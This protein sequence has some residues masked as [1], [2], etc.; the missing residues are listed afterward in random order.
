VYSAYLWDLHW[1][2]LRKVAREDNIP[3]VELGWARRE[4]IMK[5]SPW[6]GNSRP[7]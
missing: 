4:G 7:R 6:R 1:A 3:E 2:V 5:L